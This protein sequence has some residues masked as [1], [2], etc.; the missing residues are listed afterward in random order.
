LFFLQAAM[1]RSYRPPY[2]YPWQQQAAF[3]FFENDRAMID[4]Q[5]PVAW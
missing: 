2:L 4:L 3:I 1:L 5:S